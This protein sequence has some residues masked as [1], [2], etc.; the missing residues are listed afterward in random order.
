MID[1]TESDRAE[2]A[3]EETA[4]FVERMEKAHAAQPPTSSAAE[5]YDIVE[6]IGRGGMG[7]VWRA[8][9]RSV[10]R[11]IALKQLSIDNPAAEEHF[12]SEAR[13]T[14]RLSHANIV[15]VHTLG[16]S[17]NGRPMLAMKLIKGRSWRDALRV[18]PPELDLTQHL[19]VF[20]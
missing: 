4:L 13:V 16:R 9:Q 8:I 19:R 12:L 17:D 1:R 10:G 7:E 20:L 2:Q 18:E 3:P 5:V 11:E 15:P 14:A 6:P